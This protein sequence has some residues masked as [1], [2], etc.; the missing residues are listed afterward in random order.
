MIGRYTI[1]AA[2][3]LNRGRLLQPNALPANSGDAIES[4]KNDDG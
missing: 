3:G 2:A 1:G 4:K